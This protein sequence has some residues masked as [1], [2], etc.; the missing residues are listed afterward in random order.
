MGGGGGGVLL[1]LHLLFER[2]AILVKDI[3]EG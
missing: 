2:N 3:S 1:V